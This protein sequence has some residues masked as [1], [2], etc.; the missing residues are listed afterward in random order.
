MQ[1]MSFSQC[2]MDPRDLPLW[3]FGWCVQD[4]RTNP[5]HLHPGTVFYVLTVESL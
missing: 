2:Q 4:P 1:V 5:Y 3:R